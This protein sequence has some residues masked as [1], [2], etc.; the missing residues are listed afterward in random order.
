M[1]IEKSLLAA[2]F[3]PNSAITTD[4]SV[5]CD[6]LS[7]VQTESKKLGQRPEVSVEETKE[8]SNVSYSPVGDKYP[9]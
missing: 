6:T 3:K 1:K 8:G 7:S 9:I 5:E 2:W 4:E